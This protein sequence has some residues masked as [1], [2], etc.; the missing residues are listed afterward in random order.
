[1]TREW[2]YIVSAAAL[3]I[4]IIAGLILILPMKLAL[5][6]RVGYHKTPAQLIEL[7]KQGDPEAKELKRRTNWFL[8][9]GLVIVSVLFCS[10][11]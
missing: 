10:S 2:W 6:R 11:P 5:L 7:A 8:I 4:W 9:A 1:M 3:A